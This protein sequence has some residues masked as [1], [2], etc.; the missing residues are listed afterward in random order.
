MPLIPA[1]HRRK[2]DAGVVGRLVVGYGDLEICVAKCVG[3][4]L[5]YK[6]NPPSDPQSRY[7]HR[8]RYENFA[9]KLF[10]R[11][12]GEKKRI[13]SASRIMRQV[14][15]S[16]GLGSEFDTAM[17]AMRA[18]LRIRNLFA[19]CA[20]TQSKKRGLFFINLE[21]AAKLPRKLD[22]TDYRH[23]SGKTLADLETY[24]FHTEQLLQ[25]LA[26][27]FAIN[28]RLMR[29]PSP[30]RPRKRAIPKPNDELFPHK[31]PR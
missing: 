20:W 23:A 19:H 18:C 9:I 4:A 26:E 1:F 7:M 11:L 21:D 27:S 13:D 5:A 17:N 3:M 30:S 24:F 14:Y 12:R 8:I 6:R 28:T 16:V 25:F 10:F 29:G 15:T 31:S 2:K 22:L